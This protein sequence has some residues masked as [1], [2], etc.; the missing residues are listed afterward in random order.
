MKLEVIEFYTD[1]RDDAKQFLEGSM[2]VYLPEIDV[3]LRGVRVIKK[4]N[5]WKFIA[6]RK[7]G[8]DPDT[9]L[10][11]KYPVFTFANEKKHKEL[12][13]LIKTKGVEYVTKQVLNK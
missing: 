3:D 9:Q 4:K 1:K 12:L 6:P 8:V 7:Q 10:T 5:Y 2:H 11:V 13:H